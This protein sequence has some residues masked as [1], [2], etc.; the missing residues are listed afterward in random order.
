MGEAQQIRESGIYFSFNMVIGPNLNEE[1]C[2]CKLC[3]TEDTELI[4]A[5]K[6]LYLLKASGILKVIY[7]I[8]FL[9]FHSCLNNLKTKTRPSILCIHVVIYLSIHISVCTSIY[10]I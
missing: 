7:I 3:F 1:I 6:R 8:P 9:S 2:D 4:K 10:M 5:G